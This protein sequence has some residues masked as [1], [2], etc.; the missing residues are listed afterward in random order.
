MSFDPVAFL[1]L[2]LSSLIGVATGW[3]IAHW[4]WKR[5][6][7]VE[8]I[9]KELKRA[10]PYYLHPLRY[11]QFYS[12]SAKKITP[13]QQP[14][15]DTDVPHVVYAVLSHHVIRAGSDFEVLLNILDT[16]RNFENPDGLQMHDHV[17]RSV[18]VQFAGLGFASAMIIATPVDGRQAGKI[19]VRL[20]DTAGMANEQTLSF[21][22]T[23]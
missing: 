4:Y 15:A 20:K 19:T 3:A 8:R 13:D 1:N 6:A 2:V 12:Q 9:V 17:G 23:P 16:G 18:S 5:S 10:L 7:P 21:D 14:P 22:I 11:P